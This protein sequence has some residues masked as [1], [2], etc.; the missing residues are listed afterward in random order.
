M[1]DDHWWEGN[2]YRGGRVHVLAELCA[3]CVFRPG[4]L[5]ALAPGRL[6][7]LVQAN[8]AA[9]SALTCHST[10]ERDDVDNAICRGFYDR[11]ETT[12]LQ[13]ATRL[14]LVEFDPVPPTEGS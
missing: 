5:M 9:D 3:T 14:G 7:E 13:L 6:R 2:A 8:V 1:D 12:P 11:H 4:N 10:L